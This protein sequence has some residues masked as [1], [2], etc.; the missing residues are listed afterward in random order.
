M[1]TSR[2]RNKS[3]LPETIFA[4]FPKCSED[5]A[6]GSVATRMRPNVRY[7]ITKSVDRALMVTITA[8]S[9]DWDHAIGFSYGGK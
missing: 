9:P 3:T 8:F 1:A 7:R 5:R 4:S 2:H 6:I